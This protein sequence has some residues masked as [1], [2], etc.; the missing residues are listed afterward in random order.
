MLLAMKRSI[1]IFICALFGLAIVWVLLFAK[2]IDVTISENQAQAAIDK[3]IDAGPVRSRGVELTVNSATIDFK[4]NN[5]AEIT[6]DFLA[7]G[8][9]YSGEVVGNFAS[10]IRYDEPRVFLDNIVPLDIELTADSETSQ[11]IQDVKNVATD[12][13]TRQ[14][15][16]MLSE[17]AKES[18]DNIIGRNAENLNEIA[19]S[20]TYK[21]FETLPIY[22]LNDAGIKGSLASLAL[23]EVR[24]TESSAVITLSPAQALL[25]ILSFIGSV[26]LVAWMVFGFYIP[27]QKE[28]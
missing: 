24:F 26:L 1:A 25:K 28:K 20:V 27:S 10:G 21:F 11:K 16:Q 17:E 9:G 19:T 14:R 23:K 15:E 4:A 3:K 6:V 22:N 13:L 7:D 5:T 8:Y 2:T 18:L 12:F